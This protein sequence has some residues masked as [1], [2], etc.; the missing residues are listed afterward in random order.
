MRTIPRA[1]A[2]VNERDDRNFD[3]GWK[4]LAEIAEDVFPGVLPQLREN[5]P[6]AREADVPG[7][8]HRI[9]RKVRHRQTRDGARDPDGKAL[10]ARLGRTSRRPGASC[11]PRLSLGGQG[12]FVGRCVSHNLCDN[13]FT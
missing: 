3:R 7:T 11:S 4:T 10:A 5:P 6:A 9:L 13:Q 2:L 1:R 12:R 8:R